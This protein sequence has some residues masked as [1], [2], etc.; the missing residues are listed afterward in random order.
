MDQRTL[1]EAVKPEVPVRSF[2]DAKGRRPTRQ[3]FLRFFRPLRV[4]A[5]EE[6]DLLSIT[7]QLLADVNVSPRGL[8]VAGTP[9]IEANGIAYLSAND[10]VHGYE[11]WKSDGT[12]TGTVL[13]KDLDSALNSTGTSP[14]SSSPQYFT[15]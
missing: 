1:G 12:A 13:I 7:P 3:Q 14:L 2:R 6:R 15:N 5:L 9:F 11:L 8:N 10:A 4:E